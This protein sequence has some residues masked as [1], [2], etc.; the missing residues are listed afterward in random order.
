MKL[1]QADIE[2]DDGMT[3]S[4]YAEGEV[5]AC[6]EDNENYRARAAALGYG[7]DTALMSREHE[8]GHHLLA[9]WLGLPRSPTMDGLLGPGPIYAHWRTEEAAVLAIQAFARIAGVDLTE[10]A[11]KTSEG[12]P[13]S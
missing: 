13:S 9:H 7:G 3:V 6:P 12:E 5:A 2:W 4:R 8:I 1:A 10:L 11:K